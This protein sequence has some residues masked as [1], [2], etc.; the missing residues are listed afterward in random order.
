MRRRLV[1]GI[2][3]I[4]AGCLMLS[5]AR[6]WWVVGHG[7]ITEAAALALPD[8]MPAF[9]RAAGKSLAHLAGDPD[10]WK[11]REAAFLRVAE[12]PHH[13]LDLEDLDGNEIPRD[14][15]S[16]LALMQRLNRPPDKVGLLPW[17][18]MEN[19][20]RLM[21]AFNDYR[22]DPANPAITMK[23]IVYAGV[24][25]HYTTDAAMPL[26]TTRNYD[27]KP[28]PNGKMA[29]KGI[30]AKIDGFPEKNSFLAEEICRGLEARKI[31]DIWDYTVKFILESHTHVE[32]CYELDQGRAFDNPTEESRAFIMAR[33]RAG[34]QYTM[35]MW[36]NAWLRSAKLPPPPY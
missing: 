36:Y 33:C 24:L 22:N 15:F 28:G 11:N 1:I 20:D 4:A 2:G 32:K 7:T 18:I 26:H 31:D 6:A 17:A 9:F 5:A 23:C 21:V 12:A 10:R 16:G 29:Q 3:L 30:H 19:F 8:D 35:N 27:G 25:A 34:A 13:F 14:R